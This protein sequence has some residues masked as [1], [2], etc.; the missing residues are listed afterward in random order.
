[1]RLI[2]D[3][4]RT[5]PVAVDTVAVLVKATRRWPPP[6]TDSGPHIAYQ[7]ASGQHIVGVYLIH[8]YI[9]D[10]CMLEN[11]KHAPRGQGNGRKV[12]ILCF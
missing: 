5:H 7:V 9:I 8:A 3:P 4:T 2:W 1:M 10:V 11:L 12:T 6:N